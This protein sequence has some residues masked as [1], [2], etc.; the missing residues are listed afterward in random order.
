MRKSTPGILFILLAC[1]I[2][3]LRPSPSVAGYELILTREG[4]DVYYD[5][6]SES[7]QWNTAMIIKYSNNNPYSVT[8]KG[9]ILLTCNVRFGS[10]NISIPHELTL[11]SKESKE[12]AIT[13]MEACAG[14]NL[15]N[16]KASL[17]VAKKVQ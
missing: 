14:S 12:V 1:S 11:P 4:V 13:T 7:A 9:N 6:A 16:V 15:E 17:S 3:L 5:S 8:V 2:V 10:R